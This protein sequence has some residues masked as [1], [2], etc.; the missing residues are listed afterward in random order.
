MNADGYVV[1]KLKHAG[2]CVECTDSI[3]CKKAECSFLCHH[4]YSCTCYDYSNGHVCKH[5]H[6]VH[7]MCVR[8]QA[9]QLEDT[10]N[11]E[12]TGDHLIAQS[13][14]PVQ[15]N[16][17]EEPNTVAETATTKEKHS[18]DITGIDC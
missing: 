9:T 7:A 2:T 12:S 15:S 17:S 16:T 14:E 10:G 5:I 4:M 18:T 8:S 11:E 13:T 6:C 1:T 3:V